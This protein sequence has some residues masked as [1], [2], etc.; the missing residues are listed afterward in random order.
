MPSG[1]YPRKP[2]PAIERFLDV[3]HPEPNTGCYLWGGRLFPRGYGQFSVNGKS[4]SAHRWYYE[5]L[6]GSVPEG[7]ELDHIC[8][9]RC[10]ANPE[11]LKVVNHRENV[12]RGKCCKLKPN[13]TSK[14]VGV[15]WHK[16]SKKWR[17]RIMIGGRSKF[18]GLFHNEHDAVFNYNQA[19]YELEENSFKGEI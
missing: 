1:V 5:Y 17:A 16:Q 6:N 8:R 19:R 15:D 12:H 7:F 18:L 13:K 3:V 14:S 4:V 10:C 9:I 2:R 11:H